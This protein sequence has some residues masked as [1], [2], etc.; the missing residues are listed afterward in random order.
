MTIRG[1]AVWC[2]ILILAGA[3]WCAASVTSDTWVEVR[4]P[5]FRVI[6]NGGEKKAREVAVHFEQIRAVYR[7]SLPFAGAHASPLITILAAKDNKSLGQL[8]PDYWGK[9]RSHP[10][11]LFV[12][13][14]L[15]YYIL[16]DMDVAGPNPYIVIFHEYFHSLTLPF[17]PDMPTWLAEGMADF[18]ANTVIDSKGVSLGMPNENQ[19]LLLREQR[20]LPLDV[21]FRVDP[22]SPYYNEKDK[23]S[24]FYAESWALTHF[25]LLG[26]NQSHRKTLADFLSHLD[27]GESMEQA[28]AAAFGDLKQFQK[29][30][31]DYIGRQ[32]FNYVKYP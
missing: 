25:L 5:N 16:L 14:Q 11:G 18:Y 10:A 28:E 17:Y 12:E 20:I 9:E 8:L 6:S 32:S 22:A 3:I 1:N 19:L 24:I 26:D 31:N 4:S 21:L 7:S 27:R 29:Q 15:R 2:A 13:G 30:F 23:T